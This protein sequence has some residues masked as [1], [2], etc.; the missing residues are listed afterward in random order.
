MKR[1][2]LRDDFSSD[3]SMEGERSYEDLFKTPER[4]KAKVDFEDKS[5]TA[6]NRGW[7]KWETRLHRDTSW[8]ADWNEGH[9]APRRL[10]QEIEGCLFDEESEEE[11]EE[12]WSRKKELDPKEAIVMKEEGADWV[13]NHQD[14]SHWELG[15]ETKGTVEGKT[16][17]IKREKQR[18]N[19]QNYKKDSKETKPERRIEPKAHV[20]PREEPMRNVQAGQRETQTNQKKERVVER[21]NEINNRLEEINEMPCPFQMTFGKEHQEPKEKFKKIDKSKWRSQTPVSQKENKAVGTKASP[22][23]AKGPWCDVDRIPKRRERPFYIMNPY[24]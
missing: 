7:S 1:E 10:F 19:D 8:K 20:N 23:Q 24:H 16:K 13:N 6:E 14:R 12:I 11:N 2:M 22:I 17:E 4:R 9:V 15:L 3:S 18:K 21:L 5:T